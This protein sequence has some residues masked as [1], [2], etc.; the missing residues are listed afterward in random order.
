LAY[1][2]T[3][4]VRVELRHSRKQ[5]FEADRIGRRYMAHDSYNPKAAVQFWRSFAADTSQQ[6]AAT[7]TFLHTHPMNGPHIRQMQEWTP[8]AKAEFEP[9]R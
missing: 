7:P 8:A 2:V 4:K 3:S 1:E 9:T 6:G 5:K